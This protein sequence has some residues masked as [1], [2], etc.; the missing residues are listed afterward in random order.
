MLD[1]EPLNYLIVFVEPFFNVFFYMR[2]ESFVRNRF[3]FDRVESL[4]FS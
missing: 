4:V 2:I 1:L 3:R